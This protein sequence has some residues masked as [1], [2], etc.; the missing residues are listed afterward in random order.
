VSHRLA[1]P[2]Y[3]NLHGEP[4]KTVLP[5]SE[6]GLR[7]SC[8]QPPDETSIALP[9]I[10]LAAL[11]AETDTPSRRSRCLHSGTGG[12]PGKDDMRGSWIEATM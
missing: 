5:A 9:I 12:E 1:A 6:T 10:T 3:P 7:A 4:L 8:T 2:S 11:V